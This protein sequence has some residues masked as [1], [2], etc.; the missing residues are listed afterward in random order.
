[1]TL[2]RRNISGGFTLLE[3]LFVLVIVGLLV[4]LTAPR[5]GAGIDRYE[6]LSRRQALED[7]IRQLPRRA[8][9]AA[10]A[11]ELPRDLKAENLGDGSPA[12][13]LPD[14]WSIDFTPPLI[15]S[16]LGACSASAITLT[17]PDTSEQAHRYQITDLTCDL[18]AATQ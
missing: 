2:A 17:T 8:R 14:G 4:G 10:T 1:M 13:T 16:Q 7:Q 3:M 18:A 6:A 12:L 9:L 11:L 15:I 5:F